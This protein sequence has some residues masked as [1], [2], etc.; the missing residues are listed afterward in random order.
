M[1]ELI[2]KIDKSPLKNQNQEPIDEEQEDIPEFSGSVN[3]KGK[4]KLQVPELMRENPLKDTYRYGILPLS[5]QKVCKN[6]RFFNP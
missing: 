3:S 4:K 6:K 2:Q 5:F 1:D